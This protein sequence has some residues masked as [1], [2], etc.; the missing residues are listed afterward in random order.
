MLVCCVVVAATLP[1]VGCASAPSTT[2]AT[3]ATTRATTADPTGSTAPVADDLPDRDLAVAGRATVPRA[4]TVTVTSTDTLSWAYLDRASGARFQ[5]DNANQTSYTES[6]VKAWL[7]ADDLSRSA[8]AGVPAD[9]DLLVPM[10]VDSDDNAAETVW[11]NNGADESISRMIEVCQL[12]DTEVSSGWWSMTLMSA[13]DAVSLGQCVVDGTAAGPG[14][15][16]L[17]SQMRQVRGEG[18]FGIIDAL[19]SGE[20]SSVAIKNGWT[21]HYD[22]GLWRVNCLA[23]HPDWIIAVLNVYPGS[24]SDLGYGATLCAQ[25][26]TQLLEQTSQ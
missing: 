20:A 22:D 17:L 9:Y 15:D 8:A 24:D 16:W 7:A 18:R 21:L 2:A 19:T 23:I 11:L 12:V 10:I 13:R 14:T 4:P 26:T 3:P 6:M 5:S 25:V 1:A